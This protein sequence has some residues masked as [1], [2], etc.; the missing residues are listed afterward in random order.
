MMQPKIVVLEIPGITCFFDFPQTFAN[1]RGSCCSSSVTSSQMLI[2]EMFAE[3]VACCCCFALRDAR[4]FRLSGGR[5]F[6]WRC[7]HRA[8]YSPL[9]VSFKHSKIPSNPSLPHPPFSLSVTHFVLFVSSLFV[10]FCSTFFLTE[11]LSGKLWILNGVM[12]LRQK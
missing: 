12:V 4:T 10:Y 9:S 7:I 8:H 5:L 2:S 1:T 3:L 6:L 11:V